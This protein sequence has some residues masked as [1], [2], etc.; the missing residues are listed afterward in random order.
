[1]HW[2]VPLIMAFGF[3]VGNVTH[4]ES[5]S[6]LMP[7]LAIAALLPFARAF[8][9]ER[10]WG[11]MCLATASFI[12]LALAMSLPFAAIAVAVGGGATVLAAHYGVRLG[13]QLVIAGGAGLLMALVLEP[14]GLALGLW[15]YADFGLY[16]GLPPGA[17][18]S[19]FCVSALLVVGGLRVAKKNGPIP[20]GAVKSTLIVLAFATG[21]CT[22]FS[23]WPPALLGLLLLQFGFHVLHYV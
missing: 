21:V 2:I 14:A 5:F 20:L 11:V 16:Y 17:M 9:A 1:M 23:L 4:D 22:A 15:D 18:L 8:L 6:L 3:L 13:P 12:V 10:A 7:M 19:W